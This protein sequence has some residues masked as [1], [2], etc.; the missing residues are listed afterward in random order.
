MNATNNYSFAVSGSSYSAFGVSGAGNL[1]LFSSLAGSPSL[2]VDKTNRVIVYST[3]DASST[4]SGALQVAGAVGIGKSLFVER[5]AVVRSLSFS[6]QTTLIYENSNSPTISSAAILSGNAFYN[7][8]GF[9]ELLGNASQTSTYVYQVNPGIDWTATWDMYYDGTGD[10]YGFTMYQTLTTANA[11]NNGTTPNP[12]YYIAFRRYSNNTSLTTP[13]GT[14]PGEAFTS[15]FPTT[16]TWYNMKVRFIKGHIKLYVNDVLKIQTEAPLDSSANVANTYFGF[17]GWTGGYWIVIRIRNFHL[18]GNT[19]TQTLQNL[20]F[21]GPS[22]I[23]PST[24]DSSSIT[25]GAL[26]VAGGVGLGG[27]ISIGKSWRMFG[28]TS[29]SVSIAAPATV[30]SYSLVLPSTVAPA[31]NYALVSDTSGNL[32]W[33]Q[34]ITANPSFTT[35]SITST[36]DTTSATT[37]ALQV[38]GGVYIGNSMRLG[39]GGMLTLERSDRGPGANLYVGSNNV[40]YLHNPS[41]ALGAFSLTTNGLSSGTY[42]SFAASGSTTT[43]PLSITSTLDTISN[44][45]GALQ[46]T[47][48]ISINKSLR[49]GGSLI[50][51]GS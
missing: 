12:N 34:M 20:R 23:I 19:S 32:S 37:G 26:Q 8:Q 25:S 51:Q 43:V 47:G 41:G 18:T 4:T 28:A 40:A 29:G 33:S 3:T 49:L 46:V 24:S 16:A 15:M 7:S 42:F 14:V 10:G 17:S 35:A 36:V 21:T 9:V 2:I 44:T 6:N 5:D 27:S 31:N 38:A 48:G 11:I 13:S 22:V 1:V 45:T 39:W 30:T 50:M